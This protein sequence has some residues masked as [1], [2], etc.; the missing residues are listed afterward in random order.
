MEPQKDIPSSRFLSDNQ[1]Y[2]DHLFDLLTY[3]HIKTEKV[4]LTFMP[5]ANSLISLLPGLGNLDVVA[6]ESDHRGHAVDIGGWVRWRPQ[7]GRSP[8]RP[9]HVQNALLPQNRR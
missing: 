3:N 5:F 6:C 1:A 4:A 9:F 7:V 2:F 8:Q